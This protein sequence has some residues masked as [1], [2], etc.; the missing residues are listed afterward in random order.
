M[1]IDLF[2]SFNKLTMGTLPSITHLRCK[3]FGH[4]LT[5]GLACLKTWIVF[6][7]T[8][9]NT[10]CSFVRKCVVLPFGLRYRLICGFST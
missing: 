9:M 5:K 10:V 3:Y 1:I 8:S 4:E 7:R 6:I 2:D